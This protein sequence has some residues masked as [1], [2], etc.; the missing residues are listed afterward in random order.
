MHSYI[1]IHHFLPKG[2][3]KPL[4][5]LI[6]QIKESMVEQD[7]YE[8]VEDIEL[9][10]EKIFSCMEVYYRLVGIDDAVIAGEAEPNGVLVRYT[11]SLID[12]FQELQSYSLTNR[13][14]TILEYSGV[15]TIK[16]RYKYTNSVIKKLIK[17][18]LRNFKLIDDPLRIFLKGGA[19]HDL[20][21]MLFICSYPYEKEWVARTLYNFFEYNHRTDDHLL[22]GFYTVEKSSGYRGLHCDHTLFNPRFD[23]EVSRAKSSTP[24]DPYSIFDEL[25]SSD[26]TLSVLRKLKH[27]F[28]IEIQLH[29]TFES[30]WSSMEHINSYNIQAK[31]KGRNSKITVQWKLLSDSMQKLERQFEQLQI[32]TEQVRFEVL[33]HGGYLPV[34]ELFEALGSDAYPIYLKSTNK[35]EELED[36]LRSHEISRQDYV[37]QLQE[38]SY[39]IDKF[40]S[41]QKDPT[42]KMIFRMQYTFIYYG[43][44]NQREYFNSNDIDNFTQKT[45]NSY[46]HIHLFLCQNPD[47]YKSDLI[48]IIS[49]I[50]YLYLAQKYGLGMMNPDASIFVDEERPAVSYEESLLLF[51][52]GISILARL[53][54]DDIVYMG[55]NHAIALKIIHHYD[56]LTREWELFNTPKESDRYAK[57]ARDISIFREKFITKS[58]Y[59]E[60]DRLLQSDK[61]KNIGFVVNF[62][63]TLVWHGFQSPMDAL[64][65][66]IKYSS[67]DKIKASDL[68]YYELASYKFLYLNGCKSV[69]DCDKITQREHFGNYHRQNMIQLLFRIKKDESYYK[70]QK[71]RLYFEQITKT[72][73]EMDHFS[74]TI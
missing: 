44:A 61:I 4:E 47:I 30:L 8:R 27:Y 71:A 25:D 58:I 51:E 29:T 60:F 57:I 36:L 38:Q 13:E 62:Y 1:S 67:Y 35:I 37:Q 23:T 10:E 55:K 14:I 56:I 43:L 9:F 69:D 17:L 64:K 21:G 20:I 31:G 7:V 34:K 6:P 49:I 59:A 42:I 48:N 46:K 52:H 54:V 15:D 53:D 40:S 11:N 19:L 63:T 26:N 2:T 39:A 65:K 72:N 73:F 5:A 32:E 22:Y 33:H 66:I 68:F 12:Y 70:F 16:A 18:G 41:K 28:N 45:L 74:G 50:R 3:Y 24:I